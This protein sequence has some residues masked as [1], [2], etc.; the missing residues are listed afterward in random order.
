MYRD[1]SGEFVCGYTGTITETAFFMVYPWTIGYINGQSSAVGNQPLVS[2]E[3]VPVAKPLAWAISFWANSQSTLS[4][5]PSLFSVLL[6]L[7]RIYMW[8]EPMG[9]QKQRTML[10]F[11]RTFF[12]NY[13]QCLLGDPDSQTAVGNGSR[14][15]SM[16][17]WLVVDCSAAEGWWRWWCDNK[18]C[19]QFAGACVVQSIIGRATPLH[20]T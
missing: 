1:Q 4:G 9:K 8:L 3:P 18:C 20:S 2:P 17:N 14:P 16:K 19:K 13:I 12:T 5:V 6:G 7:T 15:P 11:Q 10:P